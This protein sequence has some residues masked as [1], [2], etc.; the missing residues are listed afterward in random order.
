MSNTTKLPV[1]ISQSLMKAHREYTN[2]QSCGLLFKAKY[3][4]KS[5]QS[6]PTDAMK[7]GIYFE[8]LCTGALPRSGETPEPERTTKG[9]FTAPYKRIQQSSMLFKKIFSHYN[10]KILEKGFDL[11]DDEH[12]GVIDII[13]EWDGKVVIIDLKYSGLI[14]DKWSPMGWLEEA[15]PE[16]HGLMMQG[17]HY[18][19]L[20]NDIL[21]IED[22][23]FFYFVFNSKDPTDVKII[24]QNIDPDK[25]FFHKADIQRC[26]DQLE[27]DLYNGFNALPDYRVCKDCPLF[28]TCEQKA[29][30]PLVIDVNY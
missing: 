27:K 2:G 1:K 17:V 28:D 10:I 22:V 6:Y 18:K 4:D 7:E 15:L 24:R 8:Y 5:V 29:P 14:D 25:M 23:P 19:M 30:M 16:K 26:K 21:G 3:I 9:D 11:S 20:A 12:S 13:A